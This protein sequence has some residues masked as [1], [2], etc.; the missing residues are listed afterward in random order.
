MTARTAGGPVLVCTLVLAAALVSCGDSSG[1]SLSLEEYA[2]WCSESS[3]LAVA[4]PRA[5][6][7]GGFGDLGDAAATVDA[8]VEDYES[9]TPPAEVAAFHGWTLEELRA[10]AAV[11][12]EMPSFE[13]MSS[14]EEFVELMELER[15]VEYALAGIT[16]DLD[17]ASAAL[18]LSPT[19]RGPLTASGCLPLLPP[20]DAQ[21]APAGSAI[22]I[23]W[24]PAP[25]ADSYT[26]YFDDFFDSSS[27]RVDSDGYAR[28]CDELAAE[29]LIP[30]FVHIRPA[31]GEEY[32]VT[33]CNSWHCTTI[34]GESPAGL[35]TEPEP[36][37]APTE[38]EPSPAPPTSI[39]TEISQVDFEASAPEGYTA[40][41]VW[42]FGSVWGTPARFTDDSDAGMVVYMLLGE[43]GGCSVADAHA[44]RDATA[45]IRTAPLGYLDSFESA[46]VCRST[47]ETWDSG[48]E[49]L[50]ITH[51]RVF[52][53]A[54]PTNVT[55]YVYDDETGRYLATSPAPAANRTAV[56]SATGTQEECSRLWAREPYLPFSEAI[57]MCGGDV[58]ALRAAHVEACATGDPADAGLGWRTY[59]EFARDSEIEARSRADGAYS[60]DDEVEAAYYEDLAD[61]YATEATEAENLAVEATT[62]ETDRRARI[63]AE[64]GV[65]SWPEA[66]EQMTDELWRLD[67]Y[68]LT[69]VGPDLAAHFGELANVVCGGYTHDLGDLCGGIDFLEA[70]ADALGGSLDALG[71]MFEALGTGLEAFGE[72]LGGL[73]EGLG[74]VLEGVFSIF[75]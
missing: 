59:A 4:G 52:D 1:Q 51:L 58:E 22:V 39:L 44:E 64:R 25:G 12:D 69:D 72:G 5:G 20:T 21:Y 66:C 73:A 63:I 74:G 24:E 55:E 10:A 3:P 16:E 43:A 46:T 35:I 60:A 68:R 49:G 45:Y 26:V 70:G 19:V 61:R 53:D 7:A 37:A 29:V 56:S 38:P 11:I 33:A 23:S 8:L 2:S 17:E 54:S 75:G 57:R 71:A 34:D 67:L 41:T 15:D 27:C 18:A 50:R 42:D 14:A 30:R 6:P 65:A 40:V 28:F 31:R 32:W 13:D 47:S 48:W 36:T 62:A 9:I